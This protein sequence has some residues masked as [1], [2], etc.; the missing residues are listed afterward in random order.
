MLKA[1]LI[2]QVIFTCQAAW[3]DSLD[4]GSIEGYLNQTEI[5][6]FIIGLDSSNAFTAKESSKKTVNGHKVPMFYR[7]SSIWY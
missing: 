4:N 3:Y 2:S 5:K 6:D 7:K 1:L